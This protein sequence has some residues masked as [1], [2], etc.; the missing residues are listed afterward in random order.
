MK[1]LKKELSREVQDEIYSLQSD[2]RK[3]IE[4]LI[5]QQ[6]QSKFI[7]CPGHVISETFL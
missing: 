3:K 4:E 5:S 6:V 7:I 1:I 2:H